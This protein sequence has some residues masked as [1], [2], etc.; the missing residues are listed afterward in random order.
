MFGNQV[1]A[2]ARKPDQDE[3]QAGKLAALSRSESRCGMM[4][5]CASR[6]RPLRG[7]SLRARAPGKRGHHRSC[8]AVL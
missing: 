3:Q 8:G 2:T 1:A 6:G 7:L 4:R 5:L